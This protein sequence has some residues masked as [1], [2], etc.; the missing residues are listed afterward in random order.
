MSLR[1][2]LL[3]AVR[4]DRLSD[5][6]DAELRFHIAE[7]VDE[8]IAAGL[9]E[10]EA[11]AEALRRFGNFTLQKE[12]TRDMN[13]ATW[14]EALLG[15]LRYGLRQLRLAP[16]FAAVA[17]ASLALG[18]GAN[19]AI[20]QLIN[21]LN[22]R[23]LPVRSPGELVAIDVEE[24]FFTAGWYSA[25]NRAFTLPQIEELQ[26]TQQAFDGMLAFGTTRFNLARS[27][28]AQYAQG[29]YVSPNFLELLGVRP[30]LGSG[31]LA[32]GD[33]RDC[34]NA[35][36][37][38]DYAFWQR[39]YGGDPSIIGRD[40]YLEGRMFPVV[41][42]TPPEFFG[43]EPGRRY[44]VALPLCADALFSKDGKGRLARRDAWWL[45]IVARLKPG[46]TVDRASAH[47]RD[48][49]PAL[50][51]ETIPAGY[52]PDAAEKYQKN[53]LRAVP[54]GA[55]VSSL[56]REYQDPLWILLGL[57]GLVL[58]IA[59][60]NLAN[61]LLARA[62]TRAREI[63][64]R[65]AIGASRRRVVA[66][67]ASESL[68][69]GIIGAV[70]GAGVGA[71]L[72]GLLLGFLS[73]DERQLQL[74]SGENWNVFLFTALLAVL[75]TLLFGLAPAL[76]ATRTSPASAMGGGRS[77][78]ETPDRAGMRRLLV[79]AQ[80][81]LSLILL[82]G[83]LLFGRSLR[84]L[85]A[86]DTGMTPAGVLV[87]SMDAR[88]L[89]LEP[90]RRRVVFEEMRARIA[91][92]PGVSA[93]TT[94]SLSPFS[95]NGWNGT[96]WPDGGARTDGK[97]S[98]FNRVAPAYFYTLQ[99]P[100]LAGREFDERDGPNAPKV[101]IVNEEFTKRVFAGANPVGR[102]FR[103]E[104]EA[105]Q[106]DH[107]YQIV[108]VV[109]NTK[110]NALR[111]E[112]RAIAFL[113]IAQDKEAPEGLTFLVRSQGPLTATISG[114]RRTMEEMQR[115]MLV[116]FRVLEVQ[117][118]QSVTR[119]RLMANLSGGFG[120]LAALLSTL[121]LYG[122]IAYSVARRRREIGVRIALGATRRDVLGL[123]CGEAGRLLIVG[124]AIGVAGAYGVSRYA[125]SLLYGLQ[126]GD[127]TSLALG[128][129][130]L[131]VT[132]MTAALVPARRATRVDPA[133]ALRND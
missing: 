30:T 88:V 66:Q 121:G 60:A 32:G 41:G 29:L 95:G 12:R 91:A 25:R 72:S 40:I 7:R 106:P 43:L 58:L 83:A 23:A 113:P 46:W 8:L 62:S 38:L 36:A 16:G 28:E 126:P 44:D 34:G 49:S 107:V 5:D 86:V 101:A 108:G 119:E 122:V 68:L 67:L 20:F 114:I 80:I 87:A 129:V 115:G 111:E 4:P 69:L 52:R 54:A 92:Q 2:R 120:I 105:G 81:A 17:I 11:R 130:L 117:V 99:T 98:W 24:G 102:T 96:V 10:R 27:G 19:T 127:V 78:S 100:V 55:G 123:V 109:K 85:T 56:R 22:F 45:T 6:L 82:V 50:F 84:N 104:A 132:A 93:V 118:A 59:C 35:G 71:L 33:L 15:D 9:S 26:R 39:Q 116:Q 13:I 61:L 74:R 21:E 51:R 131:T 37:V 110:Y 3:N 89:Q 75:T 1:T 124:L 94:V 77:S 76:K 112:A 90:A 79:V 65:Q 63:A 70:A 133:V 64:V 53:Q 128:C 14:L 73:N 18:I 103:H 97:E 42:V 48:L 47:M 57:T 31:Q 125:A